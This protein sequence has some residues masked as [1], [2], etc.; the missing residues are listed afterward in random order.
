MIKVKIHELDRH[1]NE[2]TFRPYLLAS[3]ALRDVGIDIT[4]SD[5]YDFAW[6]GQASIANKSMSLS[7]SVSMGVDFC[8]SISGPFI[9]FDGQDSHSL[10]GTYEV[11]KRTDAL[12]LL[13]NTLL[14]DFSMYS[15]PRYNGRWYWTTDCQ[16]SV[17]DIDQFKHRIALSGTNWLSTVPIRMFDYRA[18]KKIY[19]VS[20]LFGYNLNKGTE[21]GCDHYTQYNAHRKRCVDVLATISDLDIRMIRDGVRLPPDEY[22]KQMYF[23]KIIVAPFGYGEIAPRDIEAASF[24]CVLIK[25][26]MSHI[27]TEP[28]VYDSGTYIACKHDYSDLEEK[29]RMVLDRYEYYQEM[30][31]TN[32]R[33]KFLTQY[34]PE[35][36]A[37]Y[38]H[39]LVTS[40]LSTLITHEQNYN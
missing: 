4:R 24:G 5:D 14:R 27:I 3:N 17:E 13:K 1:R 40:K 15:K 2:T 35:R 19:D 32:M 23:S 38:M 22:Y 6:I 31:V 25:P 8:N 26:D 36:L 29:I 33:S 12:L 30:T 10:I 21:H 9:I 18:D 7:D 11:L 34:T 37:T 39:G 16:Y 20:A 28:N